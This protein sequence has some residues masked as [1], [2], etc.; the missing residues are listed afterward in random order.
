METIANIFSIGICL[1]IFNLFFKI[2]LNLLHIYDK[3]LI[4]IFLKKSKN[5]LLNKEFYYKI[6]EH[7]SWGSSKNLNEFD[8][9][10]WNYIYTDTSDKIYIINLCLF[11][12]I[13]YPIKIYG[14]QYIL[15]NSFRCKYYDL[16]KIS[17]DDIAKEYED[18]KEKYMN[19]YNNDLEIKN[20]YNDNLKRIN[21]EK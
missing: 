11:I 7:K 17:Y 19:D 21:N 6:V 13:P 9:E 20:S 18:N 8:I 4:E 5:E 10:K 1:L 12:F 2:I 14:Y 15:E 16:T 3:I